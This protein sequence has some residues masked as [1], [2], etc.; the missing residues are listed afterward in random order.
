MSDVMVFVLT[1]LAAYRLW[2]LWAE[3]AF[4]PVEW[5]RDRFERA[6]DRRFGPAWAAGTACPWCSGFWITSAVVA[7]VWA[8]QPLPLPALWFGAASTLVGLLAQRDEA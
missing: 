6:V 4:P 1:V 3:D 7:V 8:L 5:A 2:R